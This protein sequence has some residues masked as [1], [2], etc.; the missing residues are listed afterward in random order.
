MKLT[1]IIKQEGDWYVGWVEEIP[2]ANAQERS[3]EALLESLKRA[4]E[5]IIELNREQARLHAQSDYQEV[6][7]AL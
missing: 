1:A 3:Q 7:L 5:D 2:G 6:E 4:V